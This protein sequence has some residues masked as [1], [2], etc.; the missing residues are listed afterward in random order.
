MERGAVEI[1]DG[2]AG[3]V[4]GCVG[5]VADAGGPAGLPDGWLDVEKLAPGALFGAAISGRDGAACAVGDEAGDDPLA[6]G[7][8]AGAGAAAT[9]WTVATAKSAAAGGTAESA[10]ADE[11]KCGKGWLPPFLFALLAPA[12]GAGLGDSLA[13]SSPCDGAPAAGRFMSTVNGNAAASFVAG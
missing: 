4:V 8:T 12:S 5:A 9:A 11:V 10:E 1:P 7:G 3:I 6:A 2:G 13:I